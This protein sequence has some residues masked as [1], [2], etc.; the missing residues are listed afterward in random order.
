MNGIN[1]AL[2]LHFRIF[3][4]LQALIGAAPRVFLLSAEAP[5]APA[6]ATWRRCCAILVLLLGAAIVSVGAQAPS[7]T[8]RRCY[9]PP[10]YLV[11]ET[12]LTIDLGGSNTTVRAW[13]TLV[14]NPA[15][16]S[17]AASAEAASAAADGCMAAQTAQ[18]HIGQPHPLY[19]DGYGLKL[20]SLSLN[21]ACVRAAPAQM[22]QYG[23]HVCIHM[24][25]SIYSKPGQA[26]SCSAAAAAIVVC[27]DCCCYY[28][29]C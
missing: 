3:Q 13:L 7:A 24:L 27:Y 17:W 20:L 5:A 26:Y 1:W 25:S 23:M 10:A 2:L 18:A 11:P 16:A 28:C 15:H 14:P 4:P 29:C 6:S 9:A 21:G 12:N 8:W 22:Q 19:L